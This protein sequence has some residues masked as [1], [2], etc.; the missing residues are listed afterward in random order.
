MYLNNT[1][2]SI[3]ATILS[4]LIT[5][6]AIPPILKVARAKML[7]DTPCSRKIHKNEIPP[8]GG[9]AI[10]LGFMVGVTFF[11]DDINFAS[12]KYIFLGSF[13]VLLI[14]LKDDLIGISA[15]KKF[16][17]LLLAAGMIIICSNIHFTSL[18]GLFGIYEINDMIGGA[19]TLFVLL[20]IINAYNLIDGID[21]L[22]S[23]LAML[24]SAT[25]GIWFLLAG[26]FSNAIASFA[27]FGSLGGFFLF[28]VFGHKN[29]LFMG[30]T[31][32]LFVGLV[33]AIIVVKFN[34]FNVAGTRSYVLN[35][36]PV[37]SF[38]LVM[39]PL[40]DVLR[41]MTI[42]LLNGNSPFKADRN[43]IHHRLLELVPRHLSVTLIIIA[44]NVFLIALAL[45]FN[46]LAFNITMQF[47]GIFI[48]GVTVSFIPSFLVRKAKQQKAFRV[49]QTKLQTW[50][51]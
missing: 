15:R 38:A 29:K 46:F 5:L 41:V 14:G 51:D 7:F 49:D 48:A 33:I 42:R 45:F 1:L 22:A 44:A 19:L 50:P 21:G 11:I 40:I 8:L 25:F 6:L 34:E 28:N 31:G 20:A 30:D 17:I 26:S 32:S 18:H 16:G 24:A 43:H 3:F 23:G 47:L 39:V 2:L 13:L 27:L 36:A 12:L 37:I 9:L 4:F 10:F 35:S